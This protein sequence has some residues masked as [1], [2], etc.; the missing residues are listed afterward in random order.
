MEEIFQGFQ[1][2]MIDSTVFKGFDPCE[3][4]MLLIDRLIIS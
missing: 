1:V 4:S 3:M 2:S